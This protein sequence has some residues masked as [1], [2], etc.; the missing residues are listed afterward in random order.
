M[1]KKSRKTYRNQTHID[2]IRPR[3]EVTTTS[4]LI[5]MLIIVF[6]CFAAACIYEYWLSLVKKDAAINTLQSISN[7]DFGA[8]YDEFVTNLL[9]DP[10]EIEIMAIFDQ[11]GC[12]LIEY[13]GTEIGVSLPPEAYGLLSNFNHLRHV[14]NHPNHGL[15]DLD[16][17]DYGIP[18]LGTDAVLNAN[19][20]TMPY[21]TGLNNRI[22]AMV[23]I[24]G[25]NTYTLDRNGHN[26]PT[27]ADMDE[28]HYAL[29]YDNVSSS[30]PNST[31]E[32]VL[33]D[34]GYYIP[35]TVDGS[36]QY[37]ATLLFDMYVAAAMDY[38]LYVKPF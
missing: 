20:I 35:V 15:P 27:Y 32:Q 21:Q 7:H 28:I 38:K 8:T 29:Y 11:N 30:P 13:A 18:D 12:K 36:Q 25:T 19:D 37:A 5:G 24:S 1:S 17:S 34:T 2:P 16:N 23:V 6:V 31:I 9:A 22:D 26:W 10:P 14:H 4:A 3:A 33:V